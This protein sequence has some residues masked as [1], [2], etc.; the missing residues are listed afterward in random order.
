MYPFFGERNL[1]DVTN[2]AIKDFVDHISSLAP[3]KIRGYVNILKAV[4]ASA[5]DAG[6]T[7]PSHQEPA[8]KVPNG[9]SGKLVFPY[10]FQ[11]SSP[12]GWTEINWTEFSFIRMEPDESS[13]AG[14]IPATQIPVSG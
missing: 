10:S 13:V 9:K 14:S 6:F 8:A 1:A 11:C 4:V 2:L 5:R 12:V 7:L 3:A